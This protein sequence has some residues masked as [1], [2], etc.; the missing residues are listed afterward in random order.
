MA[1]VI[2]AGQEQRAPHFN[3]DDVAAQAAAAIDEARTEAAAILAEARKEADSIRAAAELAG[4]R[5]AEQDIDQLVAARTAERLA[6]CEPAF[7]ACLAE[8][9]AAR[10]DWLAAW[11]RRAVALSAA[12]ATRLVRAELKVR[13]DIPVTLVHEALQLATGA[14]RLRLHMN[15]ADITQV[16]EEVQKLL[17]RF[18][19]GAETQLVADAGITRGGCR[20]ETD[21]GVID[22][23][24]AA[25]LARITEELL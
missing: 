19:P 20:V 2:R 11:E 13:P 5:A 25:Q 3:L 8:L 23:Q 14:T 9:S 18:Q 21:Q 1:R 7:Q 12:I 10:H 4:R 16:G 15:P 17:E 24:F 22:Q 6:Q